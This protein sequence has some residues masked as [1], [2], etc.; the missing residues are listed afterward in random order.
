MLFSGRRRHTSASTVSWARRMCIRDSHCGDD[1]LVH[2]AASFDV[3]AGIL[4]RE[5]LEGRRGS[6]G[7]RA[8]LRPARDISIRLLVGAHGKEVVGDR[9]GRD[10]LVV[11]RPDPDVAQPI[12]VRMVS[13]SCRAFDDP[14]DAV[15]EWLVQGK[16]WIGVDKKLSRAPAV[17]DRKTR[18]ML[19]ELAGEAETMWA[20]NYPSA[21]EHPEASRTQFERD[22]ELGWMVSFPWQKPKDFGGGAGRSVPDTPRPVPAAD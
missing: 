14:E 13:S 20:T 10:G 19:L 5:E 11:E 4:S 8:R 1:C 6:I 12:D 21:L 3:G 17:F 16:A 7:I 9:A 18:W 22:V 15:F 2:L